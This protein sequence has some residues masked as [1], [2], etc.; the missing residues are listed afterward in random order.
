MQPNPPDPELIC[1][2]CA[3]R[4]DDERDARSKSWLVGRARF[5][6]NKDLSHYCPECQENGEGRHLI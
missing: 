3:A 6:P 4:A 5:P 2:G 1:D